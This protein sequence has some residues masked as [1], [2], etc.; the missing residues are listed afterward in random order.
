MNEA[1]QLSNL[2]HQ[3]QAPAETRMPVVTMGFGSLQSFELMQRAA[4]LLMSSTLVPVQ[5]RSHKEI[6][7]Y[8]NVVGY[9]ENPNALS[10]CVVALNMS[11]RMGA[12]V[13]MVMQNLY[14]VEG[15]PSWS[16]QFIAASINACGRFTPLRFELTEPGK[17]EEVEYMETVWEGKNKKQ[18]PR[19]IKVQH[20]QC[21]AWAKDK[22]T[23][24]KIVGPTV[25]I[26]M[27]LDEGWLTK[28]G[29][30]WQTMPEVM[31]IYRSTS[32]FGKL[33]APDLLMGLQTAE[34]VQDEFYATQDA[35]GSYTVDLSQVQ[36]SSSGFQN[37]R[38]SK[39]FD[40]K[41][42][43]AEMFAANLPLTEQWDKY[44]QIQAEYGDREAESFMPTEPDPRPVNTA[45]E[46]FSEAL[47]AASKG[48][49]DTALDLARSCTDEEQAV[50]QQTLD[51]YQKH[52]PQQTDAGAAGAKTTTGRSRIQSME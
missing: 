43:D 50:I 52:N 13:L 3:A 48:D 19:K 37:Q 14:V 21:Y 20:R 6:K 31:L 27:A 49:S 16:S 5:Y 42:L 2:R 44:Y 17:L 30:K 46:F 51:T 24:D 32:F 34:E 8:G 12:D 22:V 26:Q 4:K 40:I 1:V 29:S 11:Q 41:D 45:S 25:S 35:D 47:S 23:G 18:I 10:N 39:R 28:K 36:S 33:H 38:G 9:Q 7:E 15:R